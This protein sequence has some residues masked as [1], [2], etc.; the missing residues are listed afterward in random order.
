MRMDAETVDPAV[1]DFAEALPANVGQSLRVLR[2]GAGM[3]LEEL[4]SKAELSQPF[5]SQ[6]ENGKALPSLLA[7]HR[8]AQALGTSA[9]GLIGN[10]STGTSLVRQGEGPRFVV[11][12]G[13]TTRFLTSR[14][15]SRLG[16]SEVVAAPDTRGEHKTSHAGQEV[17]YVIAGSVTFELEPDEIYELSAGDTLSYAA[18]TPHSWTSGSQGTRFLFMGSPASF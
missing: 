18:T 10:E 4:A 1:D 3:T 16:V 13:A 12:D 17:V 5:L 7:L 2:K 14:S 8:L 6:I 9:Y 11:A 15:E